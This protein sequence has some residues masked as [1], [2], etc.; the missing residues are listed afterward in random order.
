MITTFALEMNHLGVHWSTT[1]FF[2]KYLGWRGLLIEPTHCAYQA[3][4]LRPRDHVVQAA[5][6]L[7]ET[8]IKES[9]MLRSFCPFCAKGNAIKAAYEDI[10]CA[11]ISNLIAEAKLTHIDFFSIDVEENFMKVLLTID[12]EVTYV[13]V[14]MIEANDKVTIE[15]FDTPQ[16]YPEAI[17]LLKAKGFEIFDK[18]YFSGDVF[19]RNKRRPQLKEQ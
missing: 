18:N 3:R 12:F 1:L 5:I 4:A 10:R 2:S 16:G 15:G 13:D 9:E 8:T 17:A 11:P 6:C 7:N 19:A 14:F